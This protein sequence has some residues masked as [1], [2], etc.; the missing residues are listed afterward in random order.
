MFGNIEDWTLK[1]NERRK[2]P[3][4][5]L[6]KARDENGRNR[7]RKLTENA[8]GCDEIQALLPMIVCS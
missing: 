6:R 1:Q 5:K 4:N 2:R 7:F 8:G 3:K